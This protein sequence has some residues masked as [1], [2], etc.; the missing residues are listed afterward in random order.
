MSPALKAQILAELDSLIVEGKQLCATYKATGQGTYESSASEAALKAFVT[1]ALATIARVGGVSSEYYRHLPTGGLKGLLHVA[2][3]VPASITASLGALVSLRSA[4]DAGLL[5]SLEDRL[6]ASI[7]DDFLE[8]G[9]ALLD[10]GYH[11]AAMVLIGGVLEN[12]LRKLCNNRSLTWSGK[13]SM[14][15]YNDP[16]QASGVYDKPTWR[17]IQSI[18]DVRNDA[19]HGNGAKVKNEDVEDAHKY[20]GRFLADVPT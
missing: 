17:R 8:Q 16:L 20:V 6:R 14:S 1:S 7:H 9:R 2:M 3:S 15:A 18:G 11:V 5:I 19:A 10:A 13:G 4:V 12:H